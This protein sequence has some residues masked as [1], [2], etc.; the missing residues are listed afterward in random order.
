[1]GQIVVPYNHDWPQRFEAE[2]R[3]LEPILTP[4]LRGGIHHI[5]STAVPGLAAKPIIDMLAGVGDLEAARSAF[6]P[7]LTL[8]YRYREHRPEAHLLWRDGYGIH[9]TEP[10]SDIWRERLTFRDALLT[11]PELAAEYEAWKLKHVSTA[12][13]QAPHTADKRP[14][15]ERVLAEAGIP[16]KPDAQRLTAHALTARPT[17]ERH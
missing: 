8:G 7:M 2:R 10:G 11:D 13:G 9:L 3:R 14:L 16:L 15:I 4:W 17:S 12:P 6:E 1:M 5:G